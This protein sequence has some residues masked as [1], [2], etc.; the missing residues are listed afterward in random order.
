MIIFTTYIFELLIVYI[1][2][3]FCSFVVIDISWLTKT[4]IY[5]RLIDRKADNMDESIDIN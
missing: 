3:I 4:Y 5:Q 2:L 1:N